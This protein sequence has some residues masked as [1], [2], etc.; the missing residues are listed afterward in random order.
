MQRERVR[1]RVLLRSCTLASD[2][3]E[4]HEERGSDMMGLRSSPP[5]EVAF[6]CNVVDED[7]DTRKH[8]TNAWKP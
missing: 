8:E 2:I 6:V 1:A 7:I 4:K 5:N 3:L